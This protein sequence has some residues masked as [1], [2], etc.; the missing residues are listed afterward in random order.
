[1][2]KK[3]NPDKST[4]AAKAP[5][6]SFSRIKEPDFIT[7]QA[8]AKGF[9]GVLLRRGTWPMYGFSKESLQAIQRAAFS[10]GYGLAYV[11]PLPGTDAAE[12]REFTAHL[13]GALKGLLVIAS[14]SNEAVLKALGKN[15]PRTM[16]L[17][18][19]H[20]AHSYMEVDNEGGARAAVEHLI[21][22]GHGK[23][24][25]LSGAQ[26]AVDSE[27]RLAGYKKALAARKIPF[28]ADYVL[29][30]DFDQ[31]K[32]YKA[33]KEFL[34]RIPRPTAL[35]AANDYM[36]LGA[37]SA[38]L[39]AGLTVPGDLAVVGFD[40][41]EMPSLTFHAPTLTTV[42]QPIYDIAREGAETLIKQ[43]ESRAAGARQKTF[44]SELII[45]S[46]CGAS[47]HKK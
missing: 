16:I 7:P 15:A 38:A 32:A 28:R 37:I 33:M 45:R 36:A 46:S 42:R 8:K 44:P 29:Y 12:I 31:A 14:R 9:L 20:P 24:A 26:G 22:L 1:M 35:F 10:H 30:A 21:S 17:F 6:A 4:K 41:L 43:I 47:L 34:R 3:P 2:S 18:G 13:G 27:G 5:V 39:D 11:N 25:F 23:I 19:R 40:D